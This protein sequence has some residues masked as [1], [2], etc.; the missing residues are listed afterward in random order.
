M[1]LLG[2]AILHAGQAASACFECTLILSLTFMQRGAKRYNAIWLPL[3][4][5]IF[6]S[7]LAFLLFTLGGQPRLPGPEIPM[8]ALSAR[9]LAPFWLALILCAVA[10]MLMLALVL[11]QGPRRQVWRWLSL[12][13]I[14]ALFLTGLNLYLLAGSLSR[15]LTTA[16][17][18]S[19]SGTVTL[20]MCFGVASLIGI[21]IAFWTRWREKPDAAPPASTPAIEPR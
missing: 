1:G 6:T 14:S 15:T 8:I 13:A 10:P 11:A 9:I 12:A 7:G 5:V 18:I 16:L 19:Y 21:V 4:T 3:V 2:I 20:N 17:P